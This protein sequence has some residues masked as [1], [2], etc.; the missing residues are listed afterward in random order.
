MRRLLLALLIGFVALGFGCS[1][2]DDVELTGD[3]VVRL[4]FFW[5]DT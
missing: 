1:S 3:E 5:E 2:D 4:V